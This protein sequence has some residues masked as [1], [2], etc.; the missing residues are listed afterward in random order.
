MTGL[1]LSWYQAGLQVI[2]EKKAGNIHINNLRAILL[3]E[4]DLNAAF[5]R[6]GD[7]V[8]LVYFL[9]EI[10][11][12]YAVKCL[13]FNVSFSCVVTQVFL[14]FLREKNT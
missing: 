4:G 6:V 11:F 8:G 7:Y 1:S 3:M 10:C 5:I 12:T 14:T 13:Q 2:L 9:R